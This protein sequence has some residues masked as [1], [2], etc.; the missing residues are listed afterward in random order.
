LTSTAA[1]VEIMVLTGTGL[2]NGTD[3]AL[4]NL[5]SGNSNN[6]TLT[7][8]TGNDILQ[9][10][11]GNDTLTDTTGGNNL[12]N[13]GAGADIINASSGKEL[14]IGGAGNDTI[15]TGAGADLIAF[16]RGDGQDI[17][18]ASTGADN[19]ISLG[20]G[21]KYADLNFKKNANDLILDV[22]VTEQI[23]LKD[24]YLGTTNKSVINLQ[25]I[26]EAM[27]DF[28]ATGGDPIRNSKV[29]TFNFTG[30]VDR[31]DQARTATPTITSWALT[32]ALLDFHNG[33]S[34]TA[35][36]GGDLA[37]QYGKNGNLS[38]ISFT[39]A[40]GILANA[41]FGTT[42]QALQPVANLQDTTPRLG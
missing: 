39:P 27:A 22:G 24:W 9:G 23:T 10:D 3:N 19:S 6:N 38:N 33:D 26:A 29:E 34:D 32:N 42:T 2:I 12:F 37:Y 21:I 11:A 30:L 5:L 14:F 8:T 41:G 13:G 16:N 25:M 1:N 7:A 17:V 18:N 40:Q 35:A 28:N 20:G 36:L 31:F 15:T 4:N